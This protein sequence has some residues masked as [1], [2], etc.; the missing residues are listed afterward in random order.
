[1]AIPKINIDGAK[2]VSPLECG[3]CLRICPQAI[4][5]VRPAK[6]EKFKESSE[7]ILYAPYRANCTM[8]NECVQV[9]PTKAIEIGE[10]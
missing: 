5:S 2:C 7:Y 4:F 8:C 6:L 10:G 9:C 1:M 3:K